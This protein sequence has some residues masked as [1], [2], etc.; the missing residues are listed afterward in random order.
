[1]NR[2]DRDFGYLSLIRVL[3][4]A[5]C[6]VAGPSRAHH[7]RE[8]QGMAQRAPDVLAIPLCDDCHQG[9][10]GVHGDRSR[11]RLNKLDEL[12]MLALT[13]ARVFEVM[14]LVVRVDGEGDLEALGISTPTIT[15]KQAR[16]LGMLGSQ[17]YQ[18]SCLV[19]TVVAWPLHKRRAYIANQEKKH[20]V[21]SAP[22]IKLKTAIVYEFDLRRLERNAVGK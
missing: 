5:C 17:V 10:Q 1:M 3:P 13:L 15:K 22:V 21:D 4:C 16:E 7:I 19:R 9:P 6:C 14:S 18:F 8:G 11:M 2:I 12:K 20:G